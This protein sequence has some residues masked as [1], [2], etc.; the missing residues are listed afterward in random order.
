MTRMKQ[1]LLAVLCIFMYNGCDSTST[2]ASVTTEDIV[3]GDGA[4][5][6][7]SGSW[8]IHYKGMLQDGTVIDE[9]TIAFASG[10]YFDPIGLF[11]GVSGMRVGGKRKITIPPELAFGSGGATDDTGKQI[12][13]KN[14]TLVYEVDFLGMPS[15]EYDDI[16]KGTAGTEAKSGESLTV[17]YSGT[18]EDGTSFD[19]G[20]FTFTLGSGQTISGF[21]QG[22]LGMQVGGKRKITVPPHLGYGLSAGYAYKLRFSLLIFEVEL[23]SKK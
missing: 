10:S 11:Y 3:V 1:I 15:L 9:R 23:V 14:A 19:S 12:V 8:K 17:K 6:L 13:P 2:T 20:T 18:Y 5:G 7:S 22:I 21:D 16:T 4:V